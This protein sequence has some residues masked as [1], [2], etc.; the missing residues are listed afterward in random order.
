[1][2]EVSRLKSVSL[3]GNRR[4]KGRKIHSLNCE[5]G[6]GE[7][8]YSRNGEAAKGCGAFHQAA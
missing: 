3:V 4:R 6:E 1:L 2:S 7:P 8:I 5:T